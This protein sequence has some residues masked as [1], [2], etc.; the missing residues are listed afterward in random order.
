MRTVLESR[1]SDRHF[2][3][4]KDVLDN[5]LPVMLLLLTFLIVFQFAFP[6]TNQLQQYITL[7]NWGVMAYFAVRLAVDYRL[8]GPDEQ[9]WRSHWMDILMVLPLFSIM[10]E[11]RMARAAEETIEATG[12]SEE[13][14]ATSA[15]RNSQAA[16]KLTRIFRILKRSI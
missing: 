5:I 9:F 8:S 11:A 13:L 4:T 3:A 16:A 10:Q 14:I 6:V 7:A 1:V 12:V 2:A 15:L